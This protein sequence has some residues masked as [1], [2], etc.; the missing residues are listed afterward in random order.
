LK[1]DHWMTL[2]RARAIEN[3]TYVLGA[4][5]GG[6]TYCGRSSVVDP[7]GI[8]VAAAGDQET[9]VEARLLPSRIAEA[10]DRNPALSQRRL[11]VG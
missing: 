11:G 1:E 6:P 8:V 5:Q 9:V 7:L 4:A 10:R 3:T 2:L